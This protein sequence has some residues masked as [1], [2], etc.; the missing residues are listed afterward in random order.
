VASR[1]IMRPITQAERALTAVAAGQLSRRVP[2]PYGGEAGRL[3]VSL[4]TML[5]QLEQA[6]HS[7]AASEAA[8]RASRAQMCRS[9]AD[10]GHQLRKP[11]SIVR[12]ITASYP[13]GGQLSARELDRMMRRVAGE[14]ARID[15]LLDQ[16]PLTQG[17][18]P[19][20]T[21]VKAAPAISGWRSMELRKGPESASLC[22]VIRPVQRPELPRRACGGIPVLCQRAGRQAPGIAWAR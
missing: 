2:E 10:T 22:V 21:R 3:A 4:N 19:H 17:D 1:A 15:A 8:A 13:P 20:D 5:S 14:A 9:I 7:L 12:G 6:L 16:L 11:L 18:Q